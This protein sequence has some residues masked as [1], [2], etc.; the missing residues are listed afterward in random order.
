MANKEHQFENALS[1]LFLYV[2]LLQCLKYIWNLSRVV[3]QIA[4]SLL[5]YFKETAMLVSGQ[6]SFL[7]I[8]GTTVWGM[9]HL[10]AFVDP[11]RLLLY[12]KLLSDLNPS[13]EQLITKHEYKVKSIY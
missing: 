5:V 10:V 7:N 4:I 1:K 11:S 8:H 2:S 9:S 3:I 12:E 6:Y 13:E